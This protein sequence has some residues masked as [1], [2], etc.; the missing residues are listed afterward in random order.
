MAL[1]TSLDGALAALLSNIAESHSLTS[2]SLAHA[3]NPVTVNLW[4]VT[5]AIAR[6]CDLT[7]LSIEGALPGSLTTEMV[8]PLQKCDAILSLSLHFT[9]ETVQLSDASIG[10]M[11]TPMRDLELVR[12]S[13]QDLG[14]PDVPP[15]TLASIPLILR[16]CAVISSIGLVVD[17]TVAK[18]PTLPFSI[19]NLHEGTLTLGLS[20]DPF[21]S[22]SLRC[23]IDDTTPVAAFL[24]QLTD[25]DLT[26]SGSGE[27]EARVER[28]RW[29][30]L[31]MLTP[32]SQKIRMQE[33]MRC[34]EFSV[35]RSLTD[36]VFL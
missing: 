17:A 20:F 5:V 2:I 30:E 9:A 31:M 34:V 16:H 26:I 24:S 33:R 6:H 10:E 8:K 4:A 28:D 7:H 1:Q 36:M 27:R 12:L 21:Y 13:F 22:R 25:K 35:A 32:A 23:P 3:V 15:L 11:V 19:T 18:V 14:E 29:Q